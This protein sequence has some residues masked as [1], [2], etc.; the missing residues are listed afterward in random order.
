MSVKARLRLLI[1]SAVD[2]EFEVVVA[3]SWVHLF[4]HPHSQS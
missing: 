1:L 2:F 4:Q 3:H